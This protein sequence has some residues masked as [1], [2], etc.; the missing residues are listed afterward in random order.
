MHALLEMREDLSLVFS[1]QKSSRQSS[2][3]AKP[4]F[5]PTLILVG[6]G[7]HVIIRV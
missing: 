2:V 6:E 5:D 4:Q 3:A 1:S 7:R